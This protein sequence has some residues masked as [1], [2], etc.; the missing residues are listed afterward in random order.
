MK[1]C[2][3]E[4]IENFSKSVCGSPSLQSSTYVLGINIE[5]SIHLGL[6]IVSISKIILQAFFLFTCVINQR[7]V[8]KFRSPS[9]LTIK[10]LG[11][12]NMLILLAL[13]LPVL[14]ILS[15]KILPGLKNCPRNCWQFL[16][17]VCPPEL[18]VVS[19][20]NFFF[21]L[22]VRK[23]RFLDLSDFFFSVWKMSYNA[24]SGQ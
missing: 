4:V 1:K 14:M 20:W 22:Q 7:T 5:I 2:S 21:R 16:P 6:P 17:Q 13:R 10:R 8:E 11:F 23:V 19:K 24:S 18:R 9:S 15:S 3:I 12:R